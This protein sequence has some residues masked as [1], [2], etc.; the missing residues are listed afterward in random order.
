MIWLIEQ[1]SRHFQGSVQKGQQYMSSVIE[2]KKGGDVFS[3]NYS[4]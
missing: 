3:D 2:C 4:K 1:P